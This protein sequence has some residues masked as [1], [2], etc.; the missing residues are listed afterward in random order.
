[1]R[2][3]RLW[4]CCV[5]GSLILA[6]EPQWVKRKFL[7]RPSRGEIRLASMAPAVAAVA[8]GGTPGPG[9]HA[10]L[11]PAGGWLGA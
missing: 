4:C 6:V 1:M 9:R 2:T 3:I 11:C 7:R 10:A 8:V 5:E